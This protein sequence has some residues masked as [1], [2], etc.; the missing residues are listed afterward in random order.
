MLELLAARPKL[1]V[2][3]A[4][5]TIFPGTAVFSSHKR[6]DLGNPALGLQRKRSTPNMDTLGCKLPLKR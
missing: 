6:P 1:V 5:S 3:T 2:K 4:S